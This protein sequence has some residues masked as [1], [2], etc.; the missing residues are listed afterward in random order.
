M[1]AGA[2]A[3]A[4]LVTAFMFVTLEV[5]QAFRGTFLDG[6]SIS[7]GENYAYSFAW[8]L[9]GTGLMIIGVL[10]GH[11]LLRYAALAVMAAAVF[12]VFLNDT[13]HLE[14]FLRVLS[15]LGL[16]GSLFLLAFLYQKFVVRRDRN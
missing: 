6:G 7:N 4:G 3:I 2:S 1:L 13:R 11:A 12:K 14:G 10:R 8:I 5:R 15:L 16:G 9:L